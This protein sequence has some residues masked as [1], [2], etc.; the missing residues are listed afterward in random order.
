MTVF[1]ILYR[2]R[3]RLRGLKAAAAARYVAKCLFGEV[4]RRRALGAFGLRL[5]EISLTDSCQ[6]SCPHCYAAAKDR[7][8]PSRSKE[9]SS[10]QVKRAIDQAAALGALEVCFTGGEPLLRE[11]LVELVGHA[12]SRGLLPKINTNGVLLDHEMVARL[13]DAGLAWCMVS[14]DSAYA[15]E[16]DDFRG[17]RGCYERAL[18]GLRRLLELGVPSGISVVARRE[19]L[20]TGQLPRVIALGH[21]IGA[22]VVRLLFPVP[23]GRLSSGSE[24]LTAEERREV[25][26]LTSDPLV[27]MDYPSERSTCTAAVTKLYVCTNGDVTPCVFVPVKFG[28]I[29]NDSLQEIWRRMKGFANLPKP[30][31]MCPLGERHFLEAAARCAGAQQRT[32]IAT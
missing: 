3:R 14:L 11:D 12:R 5:L 31:G 4:F 13:A 17:Y 2:Y 24:S 23:M 8:A 10:T 22:D 28:D 25:R 18:S 26:A 9:L 19:L 15:A 16:H 6:C 27:V 32:R 1:P 29:R 20:R 30:R 21:E 7:G